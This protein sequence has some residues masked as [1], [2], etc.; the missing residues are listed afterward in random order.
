MTGVFR[1]EGTR[2]VAQ[3]N[4]ETVWLEPVGTNGVRLRATRNARM[5]E[6][7]PGALLAGP[8]APGGRAGID[9]ATARVTNGRT[10]GELTVMPRGMG[11]AVEFRLRDAATGA[12]LAEEEM[13]HILWPGTRHWQAE[14]GELWRAELR[15]RAWEG[16]RFYGLGQHQH[17]RLDQKGC[18][19]DLVQ[20]NTEIAVPFLLSSRGYGLLWN[21][22]ATGRVELAAN[23]TLWVATATPQIDLVAIAGAGPAEIVSDYT[24]LTGRPPLMPD[25]VTGFWQCKLRY[26]TQDEVLE[27]AREYRRRGLPLSCLVIDFFHWTRMG[28]WRFDPEAFPDPSAMVAELRELGIEPMVSVWPTVSANAETFFEMRRQGWLVGSRR[29]ALDG[30]VFYD[31]DPRA[32][33][34]LYFYDAT[35]PAARAFHWARVREGYV[36]HGI[37]AFW[38]DA[39]EPEMYPMHPDNLRFHAG[40]GRAVANAY[41]MLHQQGYAEAFAAEGLD[42]MMLSRSAWAGAQRFPVVLWS[43][44]VASSFADLARQIPAGLSMGLSGFPWWTTDIGGFKGGD[45]GDPAFRE[46]LV[47]WFQFG[48]LSPVF[49]LHGF[50][51]DAATDP[52]LGHDFLRGGAANEV[53]S[54]GPEVQ[55]ILEHYMRLREGLRP[56]LRGL[57]AEAHETGLP[58]MRPMFLHHPEDPSAW[59]VDDAYLLGRD[60]LVAPVLGEGQRRRPVYLPQ[61]VNWQCVWTGETHPGGTMVEA[62]APLDR[63]PLFLRQDGALARNCFPVGESGRA[64]P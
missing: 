61:G 3:L 46:L 48:A 2:V 41:P 57:M 58:L 11:P 62:D 47:R 17:G 60:L 14:G 13:P 39:N 53:W 44:D 4:G 54:F 9:G 49:R 27:I 42:G 35:H 20:R 23:R 21:L 31:R 7:L 25:W 59:G 63:I 56:W 52:G 16:E 8:A 34:P 1:T 18:V 30:S 15:L 64:R 28:E 43:G 37:T 36:R 33:N 24:A 5:D 26:E 45:I 32:I 10:L 22:P 55:A 12:V 40:D 19:I 51:R 29:G 6:A 38:L 50:R